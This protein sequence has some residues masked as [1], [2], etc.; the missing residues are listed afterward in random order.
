MA[1]DQR[2][3]GAQSGRAE[4]AEPKRQLHEEAPVVTRH[5]LTIDG[6][7]LAYTA[8]AGLMPLRDD[9]DEIEAQIFFVAYT[10]E[11]E[12]GQPAAERP[13]TF[14]FNGGPGSASIWLHLGALGPRRVRLQPDGAMPP[15]PFHLIDNDD[16]WLAQTDLVFVDPVGTG[17]SRAATPEL[18]EKF[19]GYQG[20][21]DSLSEFIRLYLTRY[22]RWTSP[23]FLAGESYGTLR[24][25]G[26]AGR[27]IEMGIAL[28]GIVL[29]S[30]V[31]SYLT[32]DMWSGQANDLPF[33]LF[34]PSFA[35]A[36]WYHQRL[37]ESLRRMPLT[38]F[39]SEV[40]RFA[41][42]DYLA[43]LVRGDGLPAEERQRMVAA[44]ARR[45]GVEERYVDNSEL[46]LQIHRFCK[47]LLRD[48]KLTVGRLDSRFTGVDVLAVT[49]VPDYDPS[50]VQPTPP[51]TASFNAYVRQQLR[52]RSDLEYETL[53][54]EV[55][56]K[57]A[58][59]TGG[60][61]HGTRTGYLDTSRELRKAMVRNPFMKVL[62]A[63]GY[64]DLA[65]PYFG[66]R[67]TV[68]HLGLVHS[69]PER[70]LRDNVR[71]A[72]YEAGHM[73]YIDESAR[74]KLRGDV[75][76]FMQEAMPAAA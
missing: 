41:V 50:L 39:L 25:G 27:L 63:Y 29:I 64:Y 35:A 48:Q 3:G 2:T 13:L 24:A 33:A 42:E 9:K 28:N 37:P 51:F 12:A 11:Q 34:L 58:F 40:E 44:V 38:E 45:A 10:L 14:A 43:A 16:T 1:E 75:F 60:E 54:S 32:V 52:Y 67:Y 6:R 15:P 76:A 36:A 4:A 18:S 17:Y 20:D 57:W 8:T 30:A 22:E 74:R 7:T 19:W 47:E 69:Q 31:L 55:S 46:R 70:S 61:R 23:L 71:Y 49:D 62:V 66:I 73:M 56:R 5:Q 26:L 68:D 53:N 65:T 72:A 21:I 59:D